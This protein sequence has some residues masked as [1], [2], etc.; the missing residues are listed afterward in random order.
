MFWSM[1]NIVYCGGIFVPMAEARFVANFFRSAC[2]D[3]DPPDWSGDAKLSGDPT[4]Q[5]A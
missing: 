4:D 2:R 5:H 1:L 3:T